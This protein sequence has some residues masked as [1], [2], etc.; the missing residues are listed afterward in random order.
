MSDELI[1]RYRDMAAMGGNFHGN[2]ILQHADAIGK[3]LRQ[4]GCESMIDWGCGRGDAYASP[5]K[6]YHE[7]GL[8]RKDVTLY[9]PAFERYHEKPTRKA[10]AVV[11]SD[12]LEHIPED[13]IDDFVLDLF[14]H[15]R[16]VV[17]AS[18][19]CRPA[20]KCFPDTDINLHVT[21]RP[22]EWWAHKFTSLSTCSFV[23]L[24]TP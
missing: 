8:K 13:E 22:M 9:D 4:H 10:D 2:S 5:N 6:V 20:R 11:C 15:A 3:V 14:D 16:K 7:W 17:W 21:I 1:G 23:L 24:E 12:V 19:C 18:V